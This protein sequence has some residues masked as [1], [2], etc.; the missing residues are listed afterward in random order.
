[1]HIG[2][3]VRCVLLYA[4]LAQ[5]AVVVGPLLLLLCQLAHKLLTV[6]SQTDSQAGSRFA[7]WPLLRG[8]CERRRRRRRIPVAVFQMKFVAICGNMTQTAITGTT[9]TIT[10]TTK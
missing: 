2:S 4:D 6:L 8:R 5:V 3:G 9:T 7:W 10:T 1:M